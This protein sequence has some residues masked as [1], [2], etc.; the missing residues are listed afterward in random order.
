MAAQSDSA[1]APE[2]HQDTDKPLPKRLTPAEAFDVI[3]EQENDLEAISDFARAISSCVLVYDYVGYPEQDTAA[4]VR[5]T[6][7]IQ[8]HVENLFEIR[9]R[10]WDGLWE[11]R[12]GRRRPRDEEAAS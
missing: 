12:H 1:T 2:I 6:A 4:I 8:K 9:G 5:L 11:Y 3:N 7:E 10:A